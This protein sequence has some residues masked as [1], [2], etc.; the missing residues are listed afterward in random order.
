[1][2]QQTTA[3]GPQPGRTPAITAY[4]NNPRTAAIRRFIVAGAGPRRSVRR[5]TFSFSLRLDFACQSK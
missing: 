2:A 4:S 1:M 3:L 5:T